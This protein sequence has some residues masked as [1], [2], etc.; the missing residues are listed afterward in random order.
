MKKLIE[1]ERDDERVRRQVREMNDEFEKEHGRKAAGLT[2][3]GSSS[4]LF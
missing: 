1:D 4:Y 2:S 3:N